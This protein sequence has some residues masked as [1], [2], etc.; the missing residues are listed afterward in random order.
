[1][2]D[3]IDTS[4]AP[5]GEIAAAELVAAVARIGDLAERHYLELKGPGD[6]KSKTSKQKVAKFIL[7]AANRLT[8]KAAE[9]F[10]GCAVMILGITGSGIEGLPPIEMLELSKVVQPF[11]GIPGPRWDVF[12]VPIEDSVK[13]VLVVVVE[14]PHDGQP[15]YLCRASGD[16]LTDGRVYIRAD[17]ETREATSAE[18]DAMRARANTSTAAPVELEVSV[19]GRVAPLVVDETRTF[20][21]YIDVTR[22]RLLDALPTPKPEPDSAAMS[23]TVEAAQ[24]GS[25]VLDYA[26]LLSTSDPSVSNSV[27]NRWFGS[28]PEHRTEQEYREAID[29]WEAAVRAAW[30]MAI[31]KLAGYAMDAVE[32]AVENKTQTFMHDVEVNL[33]LEGAV[34]SVEYEGRP[35]RMSDI[36]LELPAPPREWG[37]VAWRFGGPTEYLVRPSFAPSLRRSKSSWR[38]SGSVEVE[39]DVGDL[40]PEATFVT[41]DEESVLVI[42]GEVP[43][44][45][46]GTWRAT[47]RG[48]NEV[49]KGTCTVALTK[50]R[51]LTGPFRLLLGLETT[52]G[53]KN[54]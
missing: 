19:V 13:Q 45:I 28:D 49:F 23:F 9:A 20:D 10:E 8:E 12:R 44:S 37:P 5:R 6:L 7:G 2:S 17:G 54:D 31:T 29:D 1:M 33:H 16:G 42:F 22:R 35:D 36:D 14:P 39:V 47:A 26:K 53:D 27:A 21:E 41:Y 32:I 18:Q 15:V 51:D 38:N 40:R 43:E 52:D 46:Q 11:L 34:T 3:S 50:S 25:A 4:H 24:G 48:Y 30:P